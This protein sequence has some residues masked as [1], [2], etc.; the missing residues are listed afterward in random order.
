MN[1]LISGIGLI[2]F[3]ALCN[4]GVGVP[5]R[6]RRRY[7][8]ENMWLVGHAFAMLIIPLSVARF[9][10]PD[11][12]A[13]VKAVG[14][15][16]IAIIVAFGFMWGI[17]CV[18]F[19]IGIDT[20]G[21]SL[22]YAIIMGIITAV[23]ALI[24]MA[25]RWSGIP[26]D[27]SIVILI[28]I[29]TCIAGV[30]VCGKAGIIREKAVDQNAPGSPAREP[31]PNTASSVL[32]KSA[33]GVFAIGLAWCILSGVTSAGNNLGYDFADRV[34]TEA[35]KLGT[36]PIYA[37]VARFLVVYWG[38]YLAV[39]IFC[40]GRMLKTGSWRNFAGAGA[41]RDA[42]LSFGMGAFHFTSQIAYGAGAYYVGRLGT[43]VGFAVMISTSIILANLFGFF[44]GEW[45]TAIRSS[46]RTLYLGLIMLIIAVLILAYGN[47][48]VSS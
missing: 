12:P 44:T 14:P 41:A 18:T 24:P 9:L 16:T 43:T 47:S 17:G 27:A 28:G 36:A 30:A 26:T 38:G 37:S 8:W 3:S 40:G 23:G 2:F 46:I 48:L 15:A 6:L 33:A 11:W 31:G 42:A 25:R 1:P 32:K 19:A 45:K 35:V 5:L 21:L 34:A 4:A 39:L 7:Q 20:I 22:G 29:A 10:V 13:A